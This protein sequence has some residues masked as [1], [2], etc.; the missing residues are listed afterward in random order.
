MDSPSKKGR[1]YERLRKKKGLRLHPGSGN[2]PD[3]KHDGVQGPFLVECK[4]T[5]S[6]S[7]RLLDETFESVRKASNLYGLEPAMFIKTNRNEYL[8]LDIEWINFIVDKS[9]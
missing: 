6:N 9:V 1:N 3:L 4:Y 8:V 5:D 7:Y 2:L